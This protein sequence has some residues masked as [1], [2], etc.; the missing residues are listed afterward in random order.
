VISLGLDHHPIAPSSC[1]GG[2]PLAVTLPGREDRRAIKIVPFRSSRHWEQLLI[3]GWVGCVS[4]PTLGVIVKF[5]RHDIAKLV[6]T[7]I[8]VAALGLTTPGSAAADDPEDAFVHKVAADG[9]DLGSQGDDIRLGE[10]VCA[11]FSGGMSPARVHA[12]MLNHDSGRSPRQT[13]LFMA[14][15]VQFFCPRYADLFIS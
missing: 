8:A 14:D 6:G 13:A 7:A 1:F 15:A 5:A 4:V 11:A 10:E 12:T 2:G 3:W 9:L